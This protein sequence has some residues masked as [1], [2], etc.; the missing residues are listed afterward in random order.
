MRKFALLGVVVAFATSGALGQTPPAQNGP[1][2]RP[3]NSSDS[4]NRQA[5]APVAGHNSFTETEATARIEKQGFTNVSGLQ[6]DDSGVW[7]GHAMK[8]GQQVDVSLDYQG[9]VTQGGV[10]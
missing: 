4:P 6:K 7:R 8:G 3:I 10:K 2:N 9:N 5:G 1:Q